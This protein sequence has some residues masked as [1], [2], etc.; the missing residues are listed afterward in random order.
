MIK[1]GGD[2]IMPKKVECYIC[3]TKYTNNHFK[4]FLELHID[5]KCPEGMY[6]CR[7]CIETMARTIGIINDYG[8]WVGNVGREEEGW[9]SAEKKKPINYK[10]TSPS[11]I[12]KYLDEYI[13]G[14]EYAKKT[15]SVAYY[16]HLKRISCNKKDIVKKSNILLV[17]PT[18]SGKTLIAR[19]LADMANVPFVISDAT[20]LTKKGYVGEDAESILLQL[21][22]NA[23]GDIAKAEQGIVYLDEC[24][25][26]SS[27]KQQSFSYDFVGGEGVQQA[28]LKLI[29]GNK[30]AIGKY[31]GS[32]EKVILDT[33]NI[34]FIFGGAFSGIEE[35][36]KKRTRKINNIGF[37]SD[38]T[39]KKEIQNQEI[40][41]NLTTEDFVKFGMSPEIMGRL[42]V[43]SSLEKL[44]EKQL[45][46]V[47]KEPK[48][49]ICKEYEHLFK[50]DGVELK[51]S[52]D[53]L[54][55]I[56]KTAEKKNIGARGLRSI[57]ETALN[58]IMYSLPDEKGI[59]KITVTADF[60]KNPH[61][62][63][64][65]DKEFKKKRVGAM[66]A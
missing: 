38:I 57:L 22:K 55:Y 1:K 49:S 14:Q 2:V 64:L 60:I 11:K 56:A 66:Q 28:L 58:H 17:G 18:G 37:G 48:D 20:S 54:S 10:N 45:I 35:I 15:I 21:L 19:K 39:S 65:L 61:D 43:I 34:L 33:S 12:K 7:S 23:D 59:K 16:N 29:E 53:A 30:V 47:L 32:D 8:D 36:Y 26:I 13:I 31:E 46:Q 6:I 52:D 42:P 51:F 5:E 3:G 4:K 24:D 41:Q 25:K 9:D 40:Y 63:A 27:K 50:M 62:M 44:T